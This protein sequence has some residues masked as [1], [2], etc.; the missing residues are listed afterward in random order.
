TEKFCR[1]RLVR[2]PVEKFPPHMKENICYSWKPVI[3]RATIEKARQILVYQ[4][5]SIRWTSDIVK[6]L[7]RTRTFGL[8]YHRDDFFSRISLH[9]M[10]EMFDYFGESP[11]AF[12]PFPEIGANNGM[13][14]NDP[15]VIHAVLE[16]WA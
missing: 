9:T 3:I 10:R 6:V 15:F 1:C 11:C 7:N 8:Q 13:Y 12:S 14:K 4:D 5:A 2:F 16:P